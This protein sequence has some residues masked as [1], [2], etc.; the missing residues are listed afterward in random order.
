MITIQTIDGNNRMSTQELLQRIDAAVS[1]GESEFFIEASGQHDIGGPLWHPEG[2]QLTFTV[3]NPGQR[4]GSMCLPGTEVIVEGAA[5]ADVGWLNAG[6]KIVVRGDG[7]DTTAHCAAGGTIYIGGR[8]GARSGSLMKHD[9]LEAPPEFWVLKSVG[10]FSYEFMSGGI[11]VVC[12]YGCQ[13]EESVLGD[14]SCVGMVGGKLYF[15]GQAGGISPK[16][17]KTASLEPEDIAYL[18]SRMDDFLQS[19][20]RPELRA[21]LTDWAEWRKVIP[22]TYEDRPKKANINIPAFR[23]DHWISGGL[24]SDVC[25]DDG[26]VAGLVAT[27]TCRQRVPV[28]QD[29]RDGSAGKSACSD[30]KLCLKLCPEHAVIRSEENGQHRY[31]A[32]GGRCIGCGVCSGVCPRKVWEMRVNS[33]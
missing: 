8:A 33:E 13:P 18:A 4:V 24:F 29:S 2:K 23:R 28:W 5:A 30:C 19:I 27:G 14:R 32:S 16:D 17:V 22:L 15:R 7:G 6:G 1:R 3:K 20:G 11:A 25:S 31:E 26:Q 12:G 9:P 10:S 21:A